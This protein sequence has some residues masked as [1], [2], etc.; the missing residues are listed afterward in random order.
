MK[1]ILL[2]GDRGKIGYAMNYILK[3]K[4]E[5]VGKNTDNYNALND[6]V[7]E[8]IIDEIK[9]DIVINCIGLTSTDKCE[10]NPLKAYKLN[11]LLPRTLAILSN[12]YNFTLI[13][14]STDAVFDGKSGDYYSEWNYPNPLSIYSM[15]KL[16][17]DTYISNI[18]KKYYILRLSLIFGYSP[19]PSSFVEHM[20][21]KAVNGKVLY[22]ADDLIRSPT[23]NL[24][25]AREVE[26]FLED[27]KPYGL[28]HVASKGAT[29]L[30]DLILKVIKDFELDVNVHR[31]SYK[32]FP[33][34]N[35]KHVCTPLTSYKIRP[36]RHWTFGL[37]EYIMR[38][39]SDKE[40]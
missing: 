4:Y 24:D 30:Y 34:S 15:T 40:E 12:K 6:Y 32:D 21:D 7:T 39:N 5:I 23:Y 8:R 1:K 38:L 19:K 22:I 18:A 37:N 13:H 26:Y 25:V 36:L 29:S 27:D 11:T 33:F 28:Y 31:A 16:N 10:Y 3:D 20:M 14:F 35:Y 9:P 2:L 17:A